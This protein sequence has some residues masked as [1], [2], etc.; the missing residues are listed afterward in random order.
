MNSNL[1]GKGV[2]KKL[3]SLLGQYRHA[4]IKVE[5][6]TAL[7]KEAQGRVEDTLKAQKIIQEVAEAVQNKAHRQITSVV[8][9]CLEAVFEEDAYEFQINFVQKRGK[10]E[11][12]LLMIDKGV[13]LDDP[14]HQGGGGQ[15]EVASFALRLACLLLE[16]PQRRRVLFLDEPFRNVNGDVYQERMGGMLLSLAKELNVQ[17]VIVSDDS[18]MKVGK[19]VQL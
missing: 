2:R 12:Q 4:L 3:D 8:C 10:T 6:E 14:L 11:A 18:W 15:C 17:M 1:S 9:R 7:L 13:V 19:V 5:E 16:K